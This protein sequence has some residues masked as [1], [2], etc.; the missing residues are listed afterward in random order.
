MSDLADLIDRMPL[1][2]M[3]DR[4]E[5]TDTRA[6]RE[7][8][9]SAEIQRLREYAEGGP[10]LPV[11]IAYTSIDLDDL[12][13]F[14]TYTGNTIDIHA[15]ARVSWYPE[16]DLE[17]DR[18]VGDPYPVIEDMEVWAAVAGPGL[19]M[20]NVTDRIGEEIRGEVRG[21]CEARLNADMEAKREREQCEA[22]D[23]WEAAR[24][25]Y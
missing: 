22:D 12:L 10:F 5:R 25:G 2:E 14:A 1:E 20:V 9:V 15:V 17:G 11:D 21:F 6:A 23:A 24:S 16:R 13:G 19:P 7:A 18:E 3:A 8:A 4:C